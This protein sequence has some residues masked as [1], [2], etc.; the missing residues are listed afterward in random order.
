MENVGESSKQKKPRLNWKKESVVKTFLEACIHE[1]A[2]NGRDGVSLKM[3][4]WKNVGETLKKEHNFIADQ[5]QMKNHFDYLKSKF[6][7]WTKLKNKTGNVY[8]PVTNTF[9]LTEEE[10]QIEMK[11]NKYVEP[12]RSTGLLFPDLCTQLFDGSTSNGFEGWGPASKLPN[13]CEDSANV[14]S[15]EDDDIQHVQSIPT[16]TQEPPNSSK[17]GL[18]GPQ[19]KK[20][21]GKQASSSNKSAVEEDFAKVVQLMMEKHRGDDIDA[22]MEKLEKVG[23]GTDNLLYDVAVMLFS[24]SADYRKVWMRLKPES[25]ENWVRNAGRKYGILE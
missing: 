13:D 8:D 16:S 5:R 1:V 20:R 11:S 10:W 14:V 25:L 17:E 6:S 18:T 22:C 24:E 21:K 3:L 4:S 2:V 9:N 15:V 12:V 7:A 23:W 19:S